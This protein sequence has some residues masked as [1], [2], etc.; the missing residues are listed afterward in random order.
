MKHIN[1]EINDGVA[2]AA[3]D[4][5]NRVKAK[6]KYK[7]LRRSY[8]G[9]AELP[10][11][12]EMNCSEIINS[13][14]KKYRASFTELKAVEILD[15]MFGKRVSKKLTPTP[16]KYRNRHTGDIVVGVIEYD[17]FIPETIEWRNSDGEEQYSKG[18]TIH[19]EPFK[20]NYEEVCDE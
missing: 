5:T 15:L 12:S 14:G 20:A 2:N 13:M 18:E 4:I 1:K 16:K 11:E 6:K 7:L 8:L 19:I 3:L 9:I 10:V 17:L